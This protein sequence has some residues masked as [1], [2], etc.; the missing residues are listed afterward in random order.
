MRFSRVS[1]IGTLAAAALTLLVILPILA[2][3]GEDVARN[4]AGDS[5]TVGVVKAGETDTGPTRLGPTLYVSNLAAADNEV[6]DVETP[7]YN[8]VMISVTLVTASA[9]RLPADI[10]NDPDTPDVDETLDGIDRAVRVTSDSGEPIWVDMDGARTSFTGTFTVIEPVSSGD[11]PA[12]QIEALHGDTVT[13]TVLDLRSRLTVDGEAP[14]ISSVTP[15]SGMLQA[16]ASTTVGFIVTDDDSGLHTDRE[17]GESNVRDAGGADGD[18]QLAEPLSDSLGRAVYISVVWDGGMDDERRGDRNWIEEDADRSYSLS[19]GRAGLS[20]K[21]YK[22]HVE[23]YD[24][25]GNYGRTDSSSSRGPQDHSLI[26]DDDPPVAANL[27]AGIG[28]DEEDGEEVK[29]ASS[30]L[31]VFLNDVSGGKSDALD[32]AT[33]SADKFDVIGNEV[34]D[35]I[36]P[37]MKEDIDDNDTKADDVIAGLGIDD[38]DDATTDA[39]DDLAVD[40][41]DANNIAG[42]G[43]DDPEITRGNAAYD[44]DECDTYSGFSEGQGREIDA[45]DNPTACIDT[46]NRVYLVL[47]EPLGDDETP[48]VHIVGTIRDKAGNGAA[49]TDDLEAEDRVS[50]TITVD[51]SGDVETDGRPLAQ[52]EITVKI[53]AGERLQD[54]P[55]VWLV[56]FDENAEVTSVVEGRVSSDGTNAWKTDFEGAEDETSVAAIIIQGAD[57]RDNGRTT[58]GWKKPD[59]DGPGMGDDLDL[60]KLEKAGLLVEF[61][62]EIP[63][64][65]TDVRLNPHSEDDLLK[66]ESKYPF[67]EFRF[68]EGAENTIVIDAVEADEDADPP[69]KAAEEMKFS[70]HTDSKKVETKF[71]GYSAVTLTDVTLDG[72]NLDDEVVK[73]SSAGY[74]LALANLSVGDHTLEFTATDTAGNAITEEVDFEVL[75]RSA[76]KVPL[77]PG[78]NLV[79]FPG[80][81]RDTAIDS[82][83]PADH[84]ATEVLKYDAGIWIA[85]VREAGQPWEG[86]LTDIDGQSAY[87][88]NTSSTKDLAAV[89]VQPGIGSASRPPAIPLIA[90]W[91]LIPVTD[92]D[93]GPATK[94]THDGYFSS[95]LK[96]DFV[97]GYTYNA[98]TRKW[99][100]LDYEGVVK[101]GQGVWVYSRSNVVLVP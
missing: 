44:D 17:D 85:A 51:V 95:M 79:S 48:D 29:D 3:D 67:I 5:L 84:P 38:D 20:S 58:A 7:T 87:W 82:V 35:V 68:R 75:P 46:R 32:P 11:A 54:D 6:G 26:V 61:D 2:A 99:E 80:D 64:E 36:H 34:V 24:R 28:F 69:V 40:P 37:N 42:D 43:Q 88:I 41:D 91:N 15:R 16:S 4:P 19:Y 90:G 96:E 63:F 12:G 70:S 33:I 10:P 23:A 57:R 65:E 94:T 86:E 71:D 13:I 50:P 56:K 78:W 59:D 101:N 98:V 21:T 89:L 62:A 18:G 53:A 97:R 93:Q 30:I 60:A 49:L 77:R 76:Y 14:T 100:R 81:P 55:D 31:V 74:D 45:D 25:V 83:L 27:F 22:W 66:T 92:L 1:I 72:V 73:V 47:A 8:T 52:E 39:D 9:G